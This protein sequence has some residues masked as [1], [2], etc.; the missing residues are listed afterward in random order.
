MRASGELGELVAD[1]LKPNRVDFIGTEA[2]PVGVVVTEPSRA[3]T[4][5]LLL[6]A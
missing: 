4:G 1:L 6:L 2:H 3:A 5:E